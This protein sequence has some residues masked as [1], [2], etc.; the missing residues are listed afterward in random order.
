MSDKSDDRSYMAMGALSHQGEVQP[1]TT[2]VGGQPERKRRKGRQT[3]PVGLEQV[4]YTAATDKRFCEELLGDREKAARLG[5]F[6]LTASELA[7]LKTAPTSQL[8]HMI[9]HIDTS[10]T[11]LKRRGF[12]RAVAATVVTLAASSGVE[13]CG[14]ANVKESTVDIVGSGCDM[15]AGERPDM[16]DDDWPDGG[17]RPFIDVPSK[18]PD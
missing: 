2:I 12:L 9:E 13:G 7:V 6:S 18:C 15:A 16:P 1:D 10:D 14:G 17:P 3:I 5:K 4:L 11:N 8:K